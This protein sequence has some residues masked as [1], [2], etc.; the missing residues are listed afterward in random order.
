M[1]PEDS[2]SGLWGH[3]LK[4]IQAALRSEVAH[5]DVLHKC[6]PGRAKAIP[7]ALRSRAARRQ[8][9]RVLPSTCNQRRRAVDA[10]T[11]QVET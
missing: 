11:T 5:R 10:Q 4:D 8:T 1:R 2:C 9:R 7:F 6:R 3:K